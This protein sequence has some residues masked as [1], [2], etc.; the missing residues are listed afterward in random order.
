MA[1]VVEIVVVVEVIH[2]A[3]LYMGRQTEVAGTF[4]A[5]GADVGVWTTMIREAY[6]S[7]FNAATLDMLAVVVLVRPRHT[8]LDACWV[9]K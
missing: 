7:P 3:A 8:R 1:G 5:L 6:D 9:E 4:E 2:S